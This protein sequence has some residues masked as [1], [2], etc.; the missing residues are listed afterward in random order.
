MK[1]FLSLMLAAVLTVCSLSFV[2]AESRVDMPVREGT[3][4]SIAGFNT[5]DLDGNPVT[6]EILQNADVTIINYWATWCGPCRG[7]LPYFGELA[8]YYENT[9][10]ADIQIIG[11]IS[12]GGGCTPETAKAMLEQNGCHYL[13]LRADTVLKNVFK[14]SQYIPQTLVVDRTG[15]VRDHFVGGFA[16]KAQLESFFDMWYDVIVNHVDDIATITY[17][18][19]P[20]GETIS[21]VEVPYGYLIPEETPE[22]PEIEGHTFLKWEYD[23]DIYES[24]YEDI[25]L[26]AMGDVTATATYKAQKYKVKFYDGVTGEIIK[27]QNVEHGQA[28]TAP[29]HPEHPGYVF[30]GWD[31]D[32]SC[33]TEDLNVHGICVP[34]EGGIPGDVDGN[35]VVD[36]TDAIMVLRY[37]LGV[38]DLTPEQQLAADYNGDNVIDTMDAILILRA[39]VGV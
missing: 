39:A 37:T 31:T 12:E 28:A 19:G 10:E 38:I 9:P 36:T 33:V 29:E 30:Q 21:T 13:N 2:S 1:K 14:T 16:N 24:G 3:G 20:T 7:E 4:M 22:A 17:V 8:D 5:T 23:G 6:D 18:C 11:V 27:M 32:F 35:G 25:Q 15:T 34:A 26:I